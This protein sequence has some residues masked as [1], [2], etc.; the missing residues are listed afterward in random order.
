MSDVQVAELSEAVKENRGW[1]IA[2][3]VALIILG[4][5]CIAY[6]LMATIA[7]KVFMGWIFLIGG[8]A[9]AIHSFSTRSWGGFLWDLLVGLLYIFV[10]GWLA[11]FPITGIIALTTLLA[12]T[13]IAEGIMK[14]ILGFDL[15][16]V[17]GWFWVIL[18]GIV[19][20]VAGILLISGLP[21]TAP[22]A[23]G[24]LAGINFLFS[25]W[26]FIAIPVMAKNA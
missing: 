15:R 1:F 16:P 7:M 23:I 8:I 12:L 9:Q 18:S 2:L 6:P 14:L 17:D 5:I 20:I 4:I 25:G 22:W 19:G 21:G 11:F 24:L 10:G 13:F 3:G 26:S